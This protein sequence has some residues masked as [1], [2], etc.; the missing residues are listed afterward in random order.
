MDRIK[1]EDCK[2]RRLYRIYSRNLSFGIFN[3]KAKGFIGIRE[4][5]GNLYLFTEYHWDTGPPFGTVHPKEELEL[6]PEEIECR[7]SFDTIDG[8]T[9]R[10]IKFDK[11][12]KDGGRGWVYTDTDEACPL[13]EDQK[14]Q[15]VDPVS[16]TNKPLF[17]WLTKKSQ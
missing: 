14:Y 12:R 9:D 2:H 5:F 3:E 6:L 1:L 17:D 4:K 7:E 11:P 10:P 8:K 13:T 16:P 15:D